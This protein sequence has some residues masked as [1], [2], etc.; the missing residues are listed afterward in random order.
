MRELLLGYERLLARPPTL[1]PRPTRRRTEPPG[2]TL[3]AGP[4]PSIEAL[5]DFEQAISRLPRVRE[6]AVRGYEGTDRAILDV[7]IH[8]SNPH[9]HPST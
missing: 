4:F 7:R 8:E 3:A 2:V 1:A 9:D 6:V 5:R